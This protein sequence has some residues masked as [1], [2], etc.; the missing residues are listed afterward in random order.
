V[1]ITQKASNT[2]F[3]VNRSAAFPER[4]LSPRRGLEQAAQVTHVR[5]AGAS[6]RLP[7][8]TRGRRVGERS[9]MSCTARTRRRDGTRADDRWPLRFDPEPWSRPAAWRFQLIE[10]GAV[11]TASLRVRPHKDQR[12]RARHSRDRKRVADSERLRREWG[13]SR[14]PPSECP[15]RRAYR[16][17]QPLPPCLPV[18]RRD[19][20]QAREINRRHQAPRY[21]QRSLH[22]GF[23]TRVNAIRLRGARGGYAYLQ[24]R[25]VLSLRYSIDHLHE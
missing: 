19:V 24:K 12:R 4:V 21:P 25:R 22:N 18:P 14:R 9:G 10:I 2:A 8:S 15:N 6:G 16:I 1:T 5:E 23:F 20:E 11:A 7:M 3:T 17:H 13:G